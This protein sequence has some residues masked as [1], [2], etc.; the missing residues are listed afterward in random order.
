MDTLAYQGLGSAMA[1]EVAHVER[2]GPLVRVGQLLCGWSRDGH[3]MI[4][5]RDR[6]RL[7]LVC[8]RCL[9]ETPGWTIDGS[10]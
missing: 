5:A 8:S 4:L 6:R 7:F 9:H 1:Q 10:H 2:P 3:Q